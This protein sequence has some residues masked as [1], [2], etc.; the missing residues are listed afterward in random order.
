MLVSP[1]FYPH[2]G[3]VENHVRHLAKRLAERKIEVTVLTSLLKGCNEDEDFEG[4]HVHRVKPVATIFRTPIVPGIKKYIKEKK[5]VLVHAHSPP[6]LPPYHAA[7]SCDNNLI[8]TYHCDEDI[9]TIFG[10]IIVSIYRNTFGKYTVKKAKRV[11]ASTLSY[12]KTSRSLWF[13][14]VDIV[15]MAVDLEIFHPGMDTSTLKKELIGRGMIAEEDKIVLFVGRL[16]AH[17]GLEQLIESAEK[18]DAK[19][20]I[21]GNGPLREKL[22]RE[23]RERN[24]EKKVKLVGSVEDGLLPFYYNLC[25]VFVLPSFSRLEAFGIVLL[26]AMA[27]SKPIV[28]SDIPGSRELITEGY[29]GLLAEPLNPDNLT[30]KINYL[31]SN[32]K[33]GERMGKNGRRLVEE[34]YNWRNVTDRIIEIYDE[35]LSETRS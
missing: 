15:P 26:E 33:I 28:T 25:D 21:V 32:E 16:V 30:E 2:V 34:K 31:I 10:D 8:L 24:L 20:L 22:E 14:S 11:I 17:K 19:F 5:P 9:P 35:V 6:P 1:Y 12:A 3:G 13:R 29:N 4:Y 27:C 7:R 23:I 18:V